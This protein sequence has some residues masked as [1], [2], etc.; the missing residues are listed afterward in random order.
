[1]DS[2]KK[3]DAEKQNRRENL[4]PRLNWKQLIQ[5]ALQAHDGEVINTEWLNAPLTDDR[6]WEW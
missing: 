4:S 1:M 2:L 6:D 5:K 3:T